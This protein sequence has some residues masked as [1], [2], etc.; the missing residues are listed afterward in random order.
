[1]LRGS[2]IL[3]LFPYERAASIQDPSSRFYIRSPSPPLGPGSVSTRILLPQPG[4]G[5]AAP[6]R[7]LDAGSWNLWAVGCVCGG[8]G[9]PW[10]LDS[11]SWKLGCRRDGRQ[12]WAAR[13]LYSV[14][15]KL[16][17]RGWQDRPDSVFCILY[18]ARDMCMSMYCICMGAGV[19]HEWML[20]S[21]FWKLGCQRDDGCV[22]RPDSVFC[23]LYSA[24]R[25][26]TLCICT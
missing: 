8:L 26:C 18:S 1:M 3:G 17:R 13:I 4:R 20:D 10:I 9:A 11:V 21:G 5:L 16:G 2:W 24:G 7:I 14:F 15:W 19:A 23:I 22:G 12:V 6:H 25:I